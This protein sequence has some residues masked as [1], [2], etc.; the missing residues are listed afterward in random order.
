VSVNHFFG[1]TQC[2]N[3][4]RAIGDELGQFRNL[5]EK[6]AVL[7][8]LVNDNFV[9]G[10]HT[11]PFAC[12]TFRACRTCQSFARPFRGYKLMVSRIPAR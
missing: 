4:R 12:K 2:V 10:V 11:S 8:A 5:G 7:L 1:M 3:P 6:T 9:F